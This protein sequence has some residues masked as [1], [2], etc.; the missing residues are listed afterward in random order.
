MYTIQMMTVRAVTLALTE[1]KVI[2]DQLV[3]E[4]EELGIATSMESSMMRPLAVRKDWFV[5]RWMVGKVNVN[6]RTLMVHLSVCLSFLV[7][8][9]IAR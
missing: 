7:D 5:F 2:Q 9:Y 1:V 8:L 3:E 6:R 4:L